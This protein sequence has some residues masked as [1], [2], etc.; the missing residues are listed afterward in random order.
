[1]EK[2]QL[3]VAAFAFS[4]FVI[5]SCCFYLT[6]GLLSFKWY[7]K[8][9][10]GTWYLNR[11]IYDLGRSVAGVWERKQGGDTGGSGYNIGKEEYK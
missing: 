6:G 11:Y 7:R 2:I 8:F 3:L 1:M 9:K 4:G 5:L 10:G